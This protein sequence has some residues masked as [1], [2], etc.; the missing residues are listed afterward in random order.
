LNFLR[1]LTS[2]LLILCVFLLSP[3]VAQSAIGPVVSPISFAAAPNNGYWQGFGG[4]P[5]CDGFVFA[6]DAL[7][8]GDVV[9]GGD[10]NMCDNVKLNNIGVYSPGTGR[11]RPL[12]NA[13]ANGTNDHVFA[14]RVIGNTVYVGGRFSR[15]GNAAIEAIARVDVVTG[16][17]SPV[18]NPLASGGTVFALLAVNNDLYVGGDFNTIGGVPANNIAKWN[19]SAWSTLSMGLN[20]QVRALANIGNRIFAGGEF[21]LAGNVTGTID[22]NR[23]AEWTGTTWSALGTGFATAADTLCIYNGEL[24]LG[25]SAAQSLWRWNGSSWISVSTLSGPLRALRAVDN[26]LIAVGDLDSQGIPNNDPFGAFSWDG[27]TL[28]PLGFGTDSFRSDVQ[29]GYTIINS[30]SQIYIGGDF[31]E[32]RNTATSSVIVSNLARWD[33][34]QW[35]R[36]SA[37][38]AGL[39]APVLA[40]HTRAGSVYAAGSFNTVGSALSPSLAQWNG[41]WL[42]RPNPVGATYVENA[43]AFASDTNQLL[44]AGIVRLDSTLFG[45]IARATTS[46]FAALSTTNLSFADS[47]QAVAIKGSNIYV[48]GRF[49]NI[50]GVAANNIARWDG[51][52]WNAMGAGVNGR[53]HDIEAAFSG[54]S[55]LVGGEFTQAGGLS[56]SRIARWDGASTWTAVGSGVNGPVFAIQNAF[57]EIAVGG[58]FSS[59][60]GVPAN[61]IARL[62]GNTFSAYGTGTTGPIRALTF[63]V[64]NVWAGGEFISAGGSVA[65]NIARW[66]IAANDW[67][68]LGFGAAVGVDQ[69]VRALTIEGNTVYV[70]GD[71]VVAGVEP[72]AH[73]ARFVIDADRLMVSGFEGF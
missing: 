3:Q 63:S 28:S 18:G 61:N 30:G 69:A 43:M 35:Q 33:G 2:R 40:L 72:S 73:I 53:V 31:S 21:T 36:L 44:W 60:G 9:F 39:N 5:G 66:D 34:S 27:S 56:A 54:N 70:G 47:I 6:S 65:N 13:S 20:S 59:A 42:T 51:T 23:V 11:W 4:V 1:L 64:G 41:S 57:L 48:G 22:V 16:T 45:G 38:N 37:G 52:A 49:T 67:A 25:T 32:G 68:P 7:A 19:G 58:N 55:I 71:F 14:I 24:H 15:A 46:T 50:G 29:G 17:W 62:S 12:G 10:F 26:K 8:N